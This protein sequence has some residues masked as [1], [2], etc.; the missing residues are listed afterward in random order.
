MTMQL[1]REAFALA[2]VVSSPILVVDVE[3]TGLHPFDDYVCGWV[4]ANTTHSIYVPVRHKGGGNIENPEAFERGLAH[5]F[6]TRSRLGK[7][8]IG[9]NLSFD[10]WMA[11]KQGVLI[12]APLDDTLLRAGLIQD[13]ARD[14]SLEACAERHHVT[15]KKG[16][17]L[18]RHL[19]RFARK[20]TKPTRKLMAHFHQ[21]S[22]NDPIAVEYAVGDGVT[23]MELWQAQQPLIESLGLARVHRLEADLIPHVAGLRRRGIKIDEAYAPQAMERINREVGGMM[24]SFPEGFNVYGA[25]T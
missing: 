9:H 8:T 12:E 22:G 1:Q 6:R 5:A 18:Y 13:D 3:T 19:L 10:L 25:P 11:F 20:G 4:F 24:L 23:T 16:E 2:M 15:A 21:L 17:E 14:Y 7:L